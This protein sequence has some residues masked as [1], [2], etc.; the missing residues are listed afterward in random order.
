[1]KRFFVVLIVTSLLLTL[2][3]EQQSYAQ[4]V[5]D[6][7]YLKENVPGKKPVPFPVLREADIM[8]SKKIWQ[9][10]DCR[11]KMNHHLYFPI[12][13]VDDRKSLISLL[14]YGINNEGL[15][16]YRDDEF[17][18][19]LTRDEVYDLFD[20]LPD[21]QQVADPETGD[22]VTR[23]IEGEIKFE[24][25]TKYEIK[26]QWYFDK[27]HSMMRVRI[28][29]I[30][31]IRTYMDPETGQTEKLRTFWVYFDEAR[32]LFAKQEI[33]NRNN[34]AQRISFDDVFW[35]RRFNSYIV[36]E[37]NVYNNREIVEYMQG[38]NNIME[39]EKIKQQLFEI[40]HD[41]WEF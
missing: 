27:Q 38:V 9:I 28:L 18:Q 26:E 40:E 5:N 21:T 24:Q 2:F 14:I 16:V 25:V 41:L 36:R 8:W 20:A 17:R 1:M 10:I 35:Q 22:L 33:F 11:E 34:D 4:N 19:L 31:P 13:D 7:I 15:T 39:A 29:G 6:N 32:P 30:C 23:I 12:I 3:S 37:S